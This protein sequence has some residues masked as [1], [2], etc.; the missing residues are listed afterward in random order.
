[1]YEVRRIRS[2][3]KCL[4]FIRMV[5]TGLISKTGFSMYCSQEFID[6]RSMVLLVIL[7]NFVTKLCTSTD[8]VRGAS[9]CS[10]DVKLVITLVYPNSAA[11][12]E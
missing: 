9:L 7:D 1:M 11:M 8:V 4:H 2:T 3:S 12:Q 10:A 6:L 5:Q